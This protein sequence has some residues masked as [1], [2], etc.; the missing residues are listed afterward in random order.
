MQ[1]GK[2]IEYVSYS[3]NEP[4]P[5]E[6]YISSEDKVVA[7][8]SPGAFDVVITLCDSTSEER[9][10]MACGQIVV[11]LFIYKQIP[12]VSFDYGVYSYNISLN[13]LK[14][15]QMDIDLWLNNSDNIINLFLL[16]ECSGNILNMRIAEFPLMKELKRILSLQKNMS[17]EE[18][19]YRIQEAESR[20][21]V[22]D[23]L[24]QSAF[25]DIIPA[26]KT[27][28]IDVDTDDDIIF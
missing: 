21:S 5:D 22:R 9:R 25:Y 23:M 20:Y 6:K 4:F 14:L 27:S 18:I 13:I 8:L 3:L 16:E 1:I 10:T 28:F 7:R 26:T 19:D 24:Q 15:K 11:G 12:F 2:M 17:I